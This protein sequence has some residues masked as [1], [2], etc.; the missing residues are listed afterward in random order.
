[1][2]DPLTVL[3]A[4]IGTSLGVFL[5]GRAWSRWYQG[6]AKDSSLGSLSEQWLAEQRQRSDSQR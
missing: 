1:V 5:V 3:W 2:P 6:A 4:A